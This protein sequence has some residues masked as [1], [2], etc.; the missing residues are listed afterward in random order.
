M[1]AAEDCFTTILDLIMFAF[2][3]ETGALISVQ[4]F[5]NHK[6]VIFLGIG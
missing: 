4:L 3:R 5:R 1:A 6:K 2:L